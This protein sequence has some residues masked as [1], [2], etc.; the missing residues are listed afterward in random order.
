MITH[1]TIVIVSGPPG[2]GKT[3][4][5]YSLAKRFERGLFIEAD[6]IREFVVSGVAHPIPEWTAETERQFL[7][8]EETVANWAVRYARAGF[9]VV[10]DHCRNAA[11]LNKWVE[12]DFGGY[13]VRTVALLPPLDVVLDRNRNRTNKDFDPLELEETIRGVYALYEDKDLDGWL[14]D[15]SVDSAETVLDRIWNTVGDT[16]AV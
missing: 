2:A 12:R 1:G 13:P 16:K 14:V 6:K 15:R 10:L 5:G 3:T 9:G 7:L 4:L 11:N 8:A